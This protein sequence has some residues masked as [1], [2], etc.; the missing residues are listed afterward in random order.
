MSDELVRLRL[1]LDRGV[2]AVIVEI[3][4]AARTL[5]VASS[6]AELSRSSL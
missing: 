3:R 6:E 5:R 1:V 2:G 4:V